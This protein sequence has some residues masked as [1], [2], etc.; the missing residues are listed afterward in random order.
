M[1]TV[2][3]EGK[4]EIEIPKNT[5]AAFT[6]ETP[7]NVPKLH[8]VSLWIAKRGSGKSLSCANYIKHLRDHKLVD[9]VILVS[10]TYKTQVAL[11]NFAGVEEDDALPATYESLLQIQDIM[12]EEAEE[13]NEYQKQ[14]IIYNKLQTLIRTPGRTKV[15]WSLLFEADAAG[16][17]DHYTK[18]TYKYGNRPISVYVI[19]DDIIGTE[20]F[21]TKS[22]NGNNAKQLLTNMCILHRH[23][24]NIGLSMAFLCQVYLGNF[25]LPRVIR[26]QASFLCIFRTYDIKRLKQMANELDIPEETFK[27]LH[28]FA[29]AELH[30]FLLVDLTTKDKSMKYRK[31]FNER[32]ELSANLEDPDDQT[33]SATPKPES[34]EGTAA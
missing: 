16:L 24:Q 21:G 29:T 25:A 34:K 17:L 6:I 7:V 27:A 2:P 15:D 32:I 22:A 11:W 8:Q 13:W 10:P 14:L 26:E 1:K 23:V 31:G 3:L 19:F 28:D 30:Q 33:E 5:R 12:A 18:P 20:L 4:I 9:R